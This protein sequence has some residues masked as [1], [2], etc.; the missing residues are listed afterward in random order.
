MI[1]G[2]ICRIC[3]EFKSFDNFHVRQNSQDGYRNEC[4]ICHSLICK[5]RKLK[6]L[7]VYR[8]RDRKYREINREK[9][10]ESKRIDYLKNREKIKLERKEYRENNKEKIK[11]NN[12]KNYLKNK[13]KRKEYSKKYHQAN[14]EE[15]KLKNRDYRNRNK[16]KLNEKRRLWHQERVKDPEQRLKLNLKRLFL[17]KLKKKNLEKTKSMFSST[18]IKMVEYYKYLSR[19]P[20]WNEYQESKG[21]LHIDHII[22]CSIY[23]FTDSEEIKKCWNPRNLRLLSK[24]ENILKSD[25]IDMELISKRGVQD[26]LPKNFISLH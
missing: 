8:E 20:L 23:D 11:E 3:G 25:S 21:E 6:N 24:E 15:L 4:K 16:D 2:K 22:P 10:K 13:D 1:N 14:Q 12:R 5:E 17:I 19:D 7:D 9:I 26:L 18:G